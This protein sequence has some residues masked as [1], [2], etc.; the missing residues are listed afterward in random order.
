METILQ[1][2]LDV[3][4]VN[5]ALVLDG[6]GRLVACRGKA[7]YDRALCEQVSGPLVKVID[8]IQLQQDDWETITAQFSDGRILMRSLGSAAGAAHFLAVVADGTLNL[9][10]GTVAI[11][12]AAGKLKRALEGGGGAASSSAG[13]SVLPAAPPPAAASQPLPSDSRVANTG[14]SWTTKGGSSVTLT[15]VAASDPASAA[16]L[17]QCTKE[18]ARAVGPMSK[19]Y[20]QEAVRRVAPDGT[21]SLALRA[22]LV[23]DL[24]GQIEEAADRAAFLKAVEKA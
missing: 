22:R 8:S 15:G 2:L 11:R 6:G 24:A 9:S 7:V 20:V 12:V 18:M 19:V 14:V 10:F 23:E 1:G 13:S 3:A 21:F 17:A 5:A 16:F 4:G